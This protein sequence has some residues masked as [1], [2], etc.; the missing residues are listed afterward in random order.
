ME[1]KDVILQ[2]SQP[3]LVLPHY[4]YFLLTGVDWVLLDTCYLQADRDPG[5]WKE[6][7][8]GLGVRDLLIFNKEQLSM[9]SQ[10]LVGE[11]HTHFPRV[12]QSVNRSSRTWPLHGSRRAGPC[13]AAFMRG[14]TQ[15]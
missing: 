2:H 14:V 3:Y 8:G 1:G 9:S 6:F 4:F 10:D 11:S 12:N 5:G 13:P 15:P 7:L